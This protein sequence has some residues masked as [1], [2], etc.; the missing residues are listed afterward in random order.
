L[1]FPFASSV[2]TIDGHRRQN[3]F[4]TPNSS[5]MS[6]PPRYYRFRQQRAQQPL[7]LY[8]LYKSST[9][10]FLP[11]FSRRISDGHSFFRDIGNDV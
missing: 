10:S 4:Q 2:W 5:S 3:D 6:I 8:N 11:Q 7:C 9:R 1:N